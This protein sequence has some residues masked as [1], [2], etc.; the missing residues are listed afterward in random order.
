M[1]PRMVEQSK[2]TIV[3]MVTYGNPFK[4]PGGAPEQNEIGKLW[5]RFNAYWDSHR[6]AFKHEVDPRVA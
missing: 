6:K 1:E 2:M 4:D 3:G 5:T